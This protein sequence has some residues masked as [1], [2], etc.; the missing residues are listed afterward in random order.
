MSVPHVTDPEDHAVREDQRRTRSRLQG[1]LGPIALLLMVLAY[2]GPLSGVVGYLPVVVG[3]GNGLGAPLAYAFGACLMALFA[4]GFM[5]MSS[6]IHRPGGFYSFITAGLGRDVGLGAA[7]VALLV[8]YAILVSSTAFMGLSMKNLVEETLGGPDLHWSLYGFGTLLVV[9]ILGYFRLEL[10]AKVLGVLLVAELAIVAIYDAAVVIQGGS[11]GLGVDFLDPDIFLS[12][13][14]GLALLFAATTFSG[15]EATVVFRDEVR[16]PERTIPRATY[17]FLL[18]IG[19]FYGFSAWVI[20]QALGPSQAV[21]A[22]AADPTG[23]VFATMRTFMGVFGFDAVTVLLNTSVFAAILSMHN[24]LTRYLFNLASDGVLP[25]GLAAVHASQQSP[26]RASVVTSTAAVLGLA[27]CVVSQADIAI[28]YAQLG[29][30]FGYGLLVLITVT[31]LAVL[32]YLARRRSDDVSV[33]HRLIAPA[34]ALAGLVTVVVLGTL[35]ID[36]LL[37]VSK[38]T[39]L[40]LCFGVYLLWALGAA[41]ARFLRTRRP[42][43]Y[44]TIGRQ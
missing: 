34:L 31:D 15:F 1:N 44:E 24:V 14:V 17:G 4:V 9:G 43:V 29:G 16:D 33:W 21:A 25:Q 2:N 30:I 11:E 6:H 26:H 10:S 13:S 19:V 12:G 20:T 38:E 22:T 41:Y 36:V 3:Y 39:A 23:S 40:W 42:E 7:F 5:A 18:V 37:A 32:V 27:V 8:Y 35:N 28:L